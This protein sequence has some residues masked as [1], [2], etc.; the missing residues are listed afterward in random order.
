MK[1]HEIGRHGEARKVLFA[2]LK[3]EFLLQSTQLA[4]KNRKRVC[5]PTEEGG[6]EAIQTYEF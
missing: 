6:G 5:S 1:K 2:T 4:Q 3:C